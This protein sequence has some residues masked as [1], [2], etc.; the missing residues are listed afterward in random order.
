MGKKLLFMTLVI[1]L[2]SLVAGCHR[3]LEEDPKGA[4]PQKEFVMNS[5]F[6]DKMVLQQ[7]K[8]INVFGQ[9]DPGVLIDVALFKKGD[10]KAVSEGK[11]FVDAN[12]SWSVILP[13]QHASFQL[14]TLFIND[15]VYTKE[16]DDI[17]IGEVWLTGGEGNMRWPLRYTKNASSYLETGKQNEFLRYFSQDQYPGNFPDSDMNLD[18]Q[19]D[20]S[21]GRW[22]QTSSTRTPDASA[23]SYI[24]ACELFESLNKGSAEVPVAFIESA[25]NDSSITSWLP[26]VAIDSNPEFKT[27]LEESGR[28]ASL[29]TFN[30]KGAQN[31]NQMSVLYNHK[32]NPLTGISLQGVV[33]YQG[34]S[35][36]TDSEYYDDALSLLISSWRKVLGDP[37]FVIIQEHAYDLAGLEALR[38]AQVVGSNR[39]K[40][41][42]VIPTY[43]LDAEYLYQEGYDMEPVPENIPQYPINKI[44]LA[45]RMEK[46]VETMAYASS[47]NNLPPRNQGY[48]ISLEGNY[49]M[50]RFSNCQKL[51]VKEEDVTASNDASILES[52]PATAIRHLV[53][54]QNDGTEADA[55]VEINGNAL[56]IRLEDITT[57]REIRY[58]CLSQ[59]G[60]AN[61]FNENGIP[62]LPFDI[63]LN[64]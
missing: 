45:L 42:I 36:V 31:Y 49:L 41:T 54:I 25:V 43:D 21:N 27:H 46:A 63:T 57:I 13:P 8:P 6:G 3:K 55:V 47:L 52:S 4:I 23:I 35:D 56:A 37:R 5:Y 28:Y 19:N 24:F 40:D 11:S 22:Y 60:D 14:Y 44:E 50:I 9:S 53:I 48:T 33:W 38:Q 34:F 30:T 20:F 32:I 12:G 39:L 61:L 15:S 1:L 18:P 7:N 59:N 10:H 2:G 17:L 62:V 16:I 64:W 29:E 26:K 51:T 58:A